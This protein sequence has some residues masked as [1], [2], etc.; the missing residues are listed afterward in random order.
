MFL[1][2]KVDH[3]SRASFRTIN[4]F[5]NS[6]LEN[7]FSLGS[8]GIDDFWVLDTEPPSGT[9]D[10]L[11]LLSHFQYLST[12]KLVLSNLT[13]LILIYGFY[14]SI[15]FQ[16]EYPFC[17]ISNI[18]MK[19]LGSCSELKTF[20]FYG[21]NKPPWNRVYNRLAL[22]G[23]GFLTYSIVYCLFGI[24]RKIRSRLSLFYIE[25]RLY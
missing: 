19:P 2:S 20:V 8:F 7:V 17:A 22:Y 14:K 12:N 24:A 13:L 18:R 11:A 23:F 1:S 16:F 6:H 25:R 4:I 21:F 3:L 5:R 10:T 15:Q 9:A